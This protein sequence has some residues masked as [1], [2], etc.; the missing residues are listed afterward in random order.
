MTRFVLKIA[1]LK[2]LGYTGMRRA[3][4]HR[5]TLVLS[6]LRPTSMSNRGVTKSKEDRYDSVPVAQVIG[7]FWKF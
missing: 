4:N 6:R 2:L 7:S 5:T 1:L 3:V